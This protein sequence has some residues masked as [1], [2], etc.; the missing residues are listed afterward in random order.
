MHCE[1]ASEDVYIFTSERYAQVTASLII[2]GGTGILID[3]LP[4]PNETLQIA[5]L[6]R[7][8]CPNGVRFI[9]YTGHEADHVY[10]AFLFPKAEIIAHDLTREILRERGFAALEKAKE[11]SP[12]LGPVKL[13][14]PTF[15]FASNSIV[16]RLPGKTLEIFHTPGHTADC[17]SVLLQEERLLFAG[18][19]VMGLPSIVNGDPE[20]L[21]KSLEK[22]SALSLESIIQG[23]GEII[24]RGE[25]KDSL[26]KQI[27]Y[28]DS[29]HNKVQKLIE[30]GGSRDDARAITIEQCGLS[31]VLLGGVAMQLHTANALAAYDRL[32]AQR[33][34]SQSGKRR[35]SAGK[36]RAK[37][38]TGAQQKRKTPA[39][40]SKRVT[41][42]SKATATKSKSRKRKQQS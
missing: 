37:R 33:Q 29:L 20:Q 32:M 11:Q 7:K 15:T 17:L 40:Q 12:E 23:H 30:N 3:T 38:S 35:V 14:L 28:I 6:A 25:I 4:F 21:K 27:N 22:I 31:R 42:K 10:G 41:S 24:L 9:I 34:S 26:R 2:S 18:D 39:V 8:R 13:R 36:Q 5:L 1:R 16:L 19:T